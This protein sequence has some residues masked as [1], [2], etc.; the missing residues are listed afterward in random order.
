MPETLL[1]AS[2]ILLLEYWRPIPGF[3]NFEISI[4]GRIQHYRRLRPRITTLKYGYPEITLSSPGKRRRTFYVHV[5]VAAAFLGPRPES[6]EINHKDGI[7]SNLRPSNLEYISHQDNMDHAWAT[8][9]MKSHKVKLSSRDR[10]SIIENPENLTNASLARKFGVDGSY[11][12]RLRKAAGLVPCRPLRDEAGTRFVTSA[13][14]DRPAKKKK[15]TPL[16]VMAIR[17]Q[18]ATARIVDVA[19]RFNVNRSTVYQILRGDIWSHLD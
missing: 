6:M 18:A 4:T 1:G 12:C 7:K 9:L 2:P 17:E 8:G 16:D 3:E 19:Q 14:S 5:L 15:L 10:A 11:V 13:V